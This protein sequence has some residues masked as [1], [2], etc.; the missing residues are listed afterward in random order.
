MYPSFL[1]FLNN[2]PKFSL[3]ET[4]KETDQTHQAVKGATAA[5]EA[6]SQDLSTLTK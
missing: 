2:L 5:R 1:Q 3:L 6:T 4:D